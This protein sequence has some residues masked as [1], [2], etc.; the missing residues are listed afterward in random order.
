MKVEK[1]KVE[2]VTVSKNGQ[3]INYLLV[4]GQSEHFSPGAMTNTLLSRP[5]IDF[6][7]YIVDGHVICFKSIEEVREGKSDL[8]RY[9]VRELATKLGGGGFK[10]TD[11]TV[12]KNK[13]HGVTAEYAKSLIEEAL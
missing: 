13:D 12:V 11:G 8:I 9:N 5:E 7:A 4:S 3:E 2:K 10:P 6:I 1:I